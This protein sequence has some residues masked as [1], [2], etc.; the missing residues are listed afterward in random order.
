VGIV[1]REG[2]VYRVLYYGAIRTTPARPF[3]ERLQTIHDALL[4]LIGRFE[5]TSVA[6][7]QVF[8]AF[9]VKSAMQLSQVRGIVH[10][11]AAETGLPIHEYS[12]LAVKNRVVGYGQA[13]KHQVQ[14]MVQR[15]LG[16]ARPPRSDD[17]ADA[18]ALA[19]CHCYAE[20]PRP[21]QN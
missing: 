15:L 9:N 2:R 20:A 4:E 12:A 14:R 21:R 17:A 5:P 13:K 7:E 11:V 16:L 10:L 19:L 1:E 3:G 6:V 18:L 8:Q